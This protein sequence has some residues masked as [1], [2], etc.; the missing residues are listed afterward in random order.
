MARRGGDCMFTVVFDAATV[1]ISGLMAIWNGLLMVLKATLVAGLVLMVTAPDAWLSNF[2]LGIVAVMVKVIVELI[3]KIQLLLFDNIMDAIVITINLFPS[4]VVS[5]VVTELTDIF[6]TIALSLITGF[7]LYQTIK[8]A[9]SHLGFDG[10]PVLN[11][12]IVY[13]VV[14]ILLLFL[15]QIVSTMLQITYDVS[16]IFMQ[17][18]SDFGDA[19][20]GKF[21]DLV[22]WG[23]MSANN[24][25]SIATNVLIVLVLARIIRYSMDLIFNVVQRMVGISVLIILGPISIAFGVLRSMRTVMITWLKSLFLSNFVF[26]MYAVMLFF[27]ANS[28]DTILGDISGNQSLGDKENVV[29]LF[30]LAGLVMSVGK[31]EEIVVGLF[32][33]HPNIGGQSTGSG[34]NYPG[35][36]DLMPGKNTQRFNSYKSLY[37]N[38]KKKFQPGS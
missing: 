15:K 37:K 18:L 10:E 21:P 31:V 19:V 16:N 35:G 1:V 26:M 20:G 4:I 2:L 14:L 29:K 36:D 38:A 22:Q 9:F 23:G 17:T 8:N 7:F 24:L 33:G 27:I 30:I 12:V 34:V 3:V 11:T 25:V 32:M 28:A 6:T 5:D 13:G